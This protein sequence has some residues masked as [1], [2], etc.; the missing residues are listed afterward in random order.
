MWPSPTDAFKRCCQRP[1]KWLAWQVGMQMGQWGWQCLL[2]GKN[3][4]WGCD[5][6]NT[7]FTPAVYMLLSFTPYHH[8]SIMHSIFAPVLYIST[9]SI[10]VNNC[11]PNHLH[12]LLIHK[13]SL[14]LAHGPVYLELWLVSCCM[15]FCKRKKAIST[16]SMPSCYNCWYNWKALLQSAGMTCDD[17]MPLNE[18]TP[19]LR[20][21][22]WMWCLKQAPTWS[23]HVDELV[24]QNVHFCLQPPAHFMP[25]VLSPVLCLN[26]MLTPTTT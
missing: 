19:A 4:G 8:I 25:L 23:R 9:L 24:S 3:V 2:P 18:Y 5:L 10:H 20:Y 7:K 21:V 16:R 15:V 12:A 14:S 17:M 6:V 1:W 26:G 22:K 11:T 13:H